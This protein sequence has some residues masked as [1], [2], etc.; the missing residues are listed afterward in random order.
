MKIR[1]AEKPT[2]LGNDPKDGVRADTS[3]QQVKQSIHPGFS[4]TN[5]H[6][7]ETFLKHHKNPFSTTGQN[8]QHHLAQGLEILDR[9]LTGTMLTVSSTEKFGLVVAGT[10]ESSSVKKKGK[11]VAGTFV[12]IRVAST[13]FLLAVT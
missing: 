7:P 10:C 2:V 8:C 5:H 6:I 1:P 11:K 13:V 4:S 3:I 9:P 12:S